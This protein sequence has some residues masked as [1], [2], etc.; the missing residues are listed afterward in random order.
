MNLRESLKKLPESQ[1]TY[2]EIL[3]VHDKEV[4][5]ANLL[6]FF[7]RNKEIHGLGD[8][9]IRALLKTKFYELDIKKHPKSIGSL[10]SQGKSKIEQ[11]SILKSIA[12][13]NVCT[14]VKTSRDN[15]PNKRIDIVIE[16]EDFVICIEFKINH[17]LNNPLEIYKNHIDKTYKDVKKQMFYIV[18]TPSK[19]EAEVSDIKGYLEK[20]KQFKQVIL[21]HFIKNIEDELPSNFKENSSFKYFN[22]FIQTIQNREIRYKRG[23]LLE[24]IN[25]SLINERIE[26]KYHSNN[27][28][29]FI[30][31]DKINYSLKIRIENKEFQ[32]E[33]WIQKKKIKILGHFDLNTNLKDIKRNISDH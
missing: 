3:E 30:Q 32:F 28:G 4:P 24:E 17:K 18:L 9:F 1:K 13:V 11:Q 8:L 10:I 2:L 31:I 29:G 19:K 22:D 27:K 5:I 33:K 12:N 20:N 7:F 14:E 15:D 26:S 6:A 21:N 23:L 16:T 25:N